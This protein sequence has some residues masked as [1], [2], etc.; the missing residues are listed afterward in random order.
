MSVLGNRAGADAEH[1]ADDAADAGIGTAK[2]FQSRRVIV[3]F[4]L[5]KRGRMRR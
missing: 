3:R 1:V 5:E 2:W 4:D